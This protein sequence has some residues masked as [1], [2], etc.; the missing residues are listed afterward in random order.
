MMKRIGVGAVALLAGTVFGWTADE[1]KTRCDFTP[2]AQLAAAKPTAVPTGCAEFTVELPRVRSGRTVR[3]VDFGFSPASDDNAAAI[4]RALAECRRTGADRLELAPGFYNCFGSEGVA[5]GSLRDLTLDGCGAVLIFRRPPRV[6]ANDK[7]FDI[8]VAGAN[9]VISNCE[10][11]AVRDL[12]I[13]W[14]WE[15]DPL[16]DF[17]TITA[18]HADAAPDASY[19]DF[20]MCDVERHPRYPEPVPVQTVGGMTADHTDRRSDAPFSGF[21]G[22]S[23]GHFGSKNEWVAPNVLRVWPNVKHAG[24]RYQPLY[25]ARFGAD[26]NRAAVKAAAKDVGGTYRIVHC[27]YGPNAINT[28][29]CR[30]LTLE[31]VDI[32]SAYGMGIRTSGPQHHWQVLDCHVRLPPADLRRPDG[33]LYAPYRRGVTVTADAHHVVQ[34]QGFVKFVGC[35]WTL[36]QDDSHNFHDRSTLATTVGTHRLEVVNGR[37]AEYFGAAVGDEIELVQEDF[38]RTGWKGRIVAIDGDVYTVDRPLP[39]QRGLAFV[40]FNASYGT[41]NIILRDC[42]F[43]NT[44]WA[45]SLVHGANVTVEN[46]RF[47]NITGAPLRFQIEYTWNAWCEGFGCT[48]VVVRGCSFEN[49]YDGYAAEGLCAE[50]YAGARISPPVEQWIKIGNRHVAKGLAARR[51]ANDPGPSPCPEIVSDIL[52]ERCRFLNPRG[53]AFQAMSGRNL[54]FRDSEIVFDR[55]TA[56]PL[57][58]AGGV[59]LQSIDGACVSDIRVRAAAG[60]DVPSPGV[61]TVRR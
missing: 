6:G 53:F 48:N 9:V 51:A 12:K 40:V 27:Y 36:H 30:H 16:A 33:R 55:P 32:W 29:G 58:Y 50:I 19:I 24:R 5:V 54:I 56:T 11:V 22:T 35:S 7:Q 15:R 47:R 8:P 60:T 57:P 3:A 17:A 59:F 21:Y 44:L 34:S 49:D 2:Y 61:H 52:V 31:R 28:Y 39:R 18:V 37:G 23:E 46:C 13:D 26:L 45:R 42:T 10:R 38:S 4:N 1:L 14:D 43:A 25:D 41:D 20:K